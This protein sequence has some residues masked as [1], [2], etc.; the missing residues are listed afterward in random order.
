MLC[1][2]QAFIG[3]VN[4][5]KENIEQLLATRCFPEGRK[6]IF[7]L[8]WYYRQRY[9]WYF[10]RKISILP[11]SYNVS[12]FCRIKVLCFGVVLW[13]QLVGIANR[14]SSVLVAGCGGDKS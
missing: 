5:K 8:L 4:D 7:L 1:A 6:T 14:G 13:I 10:S 2:G 12:H 3:F 11:R 9:D